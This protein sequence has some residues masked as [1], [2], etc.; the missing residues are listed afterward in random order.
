M[1]ISILLLQSAVLLIIT[2]WMIWMQLRGHALFVS[3]PP[4][5][6]EIKPYGFGR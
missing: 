1:Y 3:T 4:R 2:T 5:I 6:I